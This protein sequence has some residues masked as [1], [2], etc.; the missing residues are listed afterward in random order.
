M[1]CCNLGCWDGVEELVLDDFMVRDTFVWHMGLDWDIE[2]G[3]FSALY[4]SVWHSW[5]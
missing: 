5:I 3:L 2:I 1:I 4:D